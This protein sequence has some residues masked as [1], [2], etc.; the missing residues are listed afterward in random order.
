[1]LTVHGSTIS[2]RPGSRRGVAPSAH[3]EPGRC[4]Q[5]QA[6]FEVLLVLPRRFSTT[7]AG[8]ARIRGAFFRK[9]AKEL[10]LE[11]EHP[12]GMRFQR[13]FASIKHGVMPCLVQMGQLSTEIVIAEG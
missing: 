8:P 9:A 1:V 11:A 12:A 13:I 3:L 7:G 4:P 10:L 6:G 2:T 5:R